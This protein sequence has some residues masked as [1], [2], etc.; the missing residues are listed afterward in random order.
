[1]SLV[2][3]G[4]TDV[5]TSNDF[6]SVTEPLHQYVAAPAIVP[7]AGTLQSLSL[8]TRLG[9]STFK[10]ALYDNSGSGGKPGA[11]IAETAEGT[12]VEANWVT[13]NTLTHP[14]LTAGQAVYLCLIV[15]NANVHIKVF[16]GVAGIYYD[17][18][19]G[20]PTVNSPC[21]AQTYYAEKVSIYGTL[22]SGNRR[23]RILCCA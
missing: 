20:Y 23:R 16:P 22:A 7:V 15:G 18:A 10:L 12:A 11:K 14:S 1:M 8:Y 4:N 19:T 2:E 3:F 9:G 5:G 6:G 13:L 17:A 21:P